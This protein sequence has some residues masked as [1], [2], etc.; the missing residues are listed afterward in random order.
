MSSFLFERL[1]ASKD[2]KSVMKLANKGQTIER[3]ED[4]LK[5]PFVLDFLGY[6]KHHS[7]TETQLAG[8]IIN[9]LQDFLLEMG[10]GFTFIAKQK[11][12]H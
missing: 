6:K 1:T 4:T 8:A 9:H 12:T 2:A 11:F 5:N 3:P 7:Y 10:R